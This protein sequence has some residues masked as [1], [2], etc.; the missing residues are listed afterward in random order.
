MRD[1]IQALVCSGGRSRSRTQVSKRNE[2]AGFY[3]CCFWALLLLFYSRIISFFSYW[4]L[5]SSEFYK[6]SRQ[7][8]D[9][10]GEPLSS[11]LDAP[12]ASK[13]GTIVRRVGVR[14]GSHRL[15][16]ILWLWKIKKKICFLYFSNVGSNISVWG[17]ADSKKPFHKG[18]VKGDSS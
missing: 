14:M 8:S 2:G 17:E 15:P 11:F 1:W 13:N 6:E 5:W 12:A 3:F 16:L 9:A 18:E 10:K 4:A 7:R